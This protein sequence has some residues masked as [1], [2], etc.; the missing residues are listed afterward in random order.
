[1]GPYL[2][3]RIASVHESGQQIGWILVHQGIRRFDD[4]EEGPYLQIIVHDMTQGSTFDDFQDD[5]DVCEEILAKLSE[6]FMDWF[7]R[8]LTIEWLDAQA[9]SSVGIMLGWSAEDSD[10]G[11]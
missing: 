6:G 10:P 4:G 11:V 2:I 3:G 5:P 8:I 7:G 9:A 1:M